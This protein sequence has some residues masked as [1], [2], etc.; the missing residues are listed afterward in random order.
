MRCRN[1]ARMRPSTTSTLSKMSQSDG[2][3]ENRWF[4]VVRRGRAKMRERRDVPNPSNNPTIPRPNTHNL[5]P[6]III[7]RE[8]AVLMPRSVYSVRGP[9][10]IEM[11]GTVGGW[12]G[13]GTVHVGAVGA[14][15]GM[16]RLRG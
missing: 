7:D 14:V 6:P 16:K 5:H 1:L 13:A 10:A 15:G 11:A 4:H 8:L 9:I 12:G 2:A 3:K